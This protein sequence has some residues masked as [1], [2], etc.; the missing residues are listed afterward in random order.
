MKAHH[1]VTATLTTLIHNIPNTAVASSTQ[2]RY[3][4][5]AVHA[6]DLETS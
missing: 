4:R 6:A 1:F 2:L 5:F 3:V